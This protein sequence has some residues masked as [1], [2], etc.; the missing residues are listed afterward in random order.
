VLR[1]Q[2]NRLLDPRH[3]A[4]EEFDRHKLTSDEKQLF[5]ISTERAQASN[6]RVYVAL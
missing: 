6:T 4:S 2:P 3:E 1:K 5:R